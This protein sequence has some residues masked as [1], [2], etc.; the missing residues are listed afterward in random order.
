M[1][2][3]L[4]CFLYVTNDP[5][6]WPSM[7][8]TVIIGAYIGAVVYDGILKEVKKMMLSLSVYALMI[9]TVDITRVIPQINAGLVNDVRKPIASVAT[10]ILVTIFYALGMYLGV[11][12]V[13]K[14]HD[15]KNMHSSRTRQ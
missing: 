13:N 1:N 7:A 12:M 14:A 3:I 10:I 5:F 6:F 11:K 4:Q 15:E 9:L 2:S 8:F